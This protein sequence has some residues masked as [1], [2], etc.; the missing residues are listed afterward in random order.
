[1]LSSVYSMTEETKFL[2][3]MFLQV[4]QRHEHGYVG[5]QI[6][7]FTAYSLGNISAKQLPKSVNVR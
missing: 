4:V 6:T 7:Q 2:G 1:M 3:F 5:E